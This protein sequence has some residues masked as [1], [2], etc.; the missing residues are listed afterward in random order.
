MNYNSP[1]RDELLKKLTALD[2]V[3][4]DLALFL[5]THPCD[6]EAILAYNCVINEASEVRQE[7]E[8][9]FGPLC[10]F[11]SCSEEERFDWI[12]SPW[13]WE[14]TFNYSLSGREY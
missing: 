10:S 4:V 2:F 6:K 11:R 13:P 3:A 5:N 9:N 14:Y 1:V 8:D 12:N 7:Y